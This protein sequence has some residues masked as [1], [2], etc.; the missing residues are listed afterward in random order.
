MKLPLVRKSNKQCQNK[1][2]KD[3]LIKKDFLKGFV[4]RNDILKIHKTVT[5]KKYL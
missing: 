5:M 1:W 3:F 4:T 2:N